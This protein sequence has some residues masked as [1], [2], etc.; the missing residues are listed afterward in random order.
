VNKDS[1]TIGLQGTYNE[2][3]TSGPTFVSLVET[4]DKGK[5]DLKQG[6]DSTNGT[7][8]GSEEDMKEKEK[9]KDTKQKHGGHQIQSSS[10]LIEE[11]ERSIGVIDKNVLQFFFSAA[12]TSW[13]LLILA[14]L[15]LV[16]S[17]VAILGSE[18]W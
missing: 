3:L 11:E 1:Y 16:S 5:E 13:W 6:H 12:G 4:F 10:K 9:E 14:M 15:F 2:L 7:A 18:F 8:A 17:Y